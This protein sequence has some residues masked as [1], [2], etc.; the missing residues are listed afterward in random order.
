MEQPIGPEP[1]FVTVSPRRHRAN[2]MIDASAFIA[3]TM[4]ARLVLLTKC[5]KG[6]A[7]PISTPI[8][9]HVRLNE[10]QATKPFFVFEIGEETQREKLFGAGTTDDEGNSVYF[11]PFTA[12]LHVAEEK[13]SIDVWSLKYNTTDDDISAAL[14]RYGVVERVSSSLNGK[15][16]M[17]KATVLFESEAAVESMQQNQV[18]CVNIGSDTG[19]VRRLGTSNITFNPELTLKLTNLPRQYTPYDVALLLN[20][21]GKWHGITMPFQPRLG[22]RLPEAFVFFSNKEQQATLS[23]QKFVLDDVSGLP[24]TTSW[25]SPSTPTCFQCGAT[26]HRRAEGCP[27]RQHFLA[28][29]EKRRMNN[30]RIFSKVNTPHPRVTTQVSHGATPVTTRRKPAA[31]GN[32]WASGTLPHQQPTQSRAPVTITSVSQTT[33]STD[34]A[35][36]WKLALDTMS[37]SVNERFQAMQAANAHNFQSLDNTISTLATM[38]QQLIPGNNVAPAEQVTFTQYAPQHVAIEEDMSMDGNFNTVETEEEEED[39]LDTPLERNVAHKNNGKRIA[40]SAPSTKTLAKERQ[41]HLRSQT[42]SNTQDLLQEVQEL[43]V[44]KQQAQNEIRLQADAIRQLQVQLAGILQS[45][46]STILSPTPQPGQVF[47][48]STQLSPNTQL[49]F[50]SPQTVTQSSVDIPSFN[51]HPSPESS[52]A[53]MTTPEFTNSNTSQY[54][55]NNLS[56]TAPNV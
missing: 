5:M 22:R 36:A 45:Q 49:N 27:Q 7:V 56:P 50:G 39:D 41:Q 32:V 47:V 25:V 44:F 31:A 9:R 33:T 17:R 13:R 14:S 40:V 6:I 16:T 30:Q 24:K 28:I 10:G 11:I 51:T 3:P 29:A 46:S 48:Q 43:R 34:R 55:V 15:H 53:W 54:S 18:S 4:K 12:D 20:N 35:P 8:I 2:V 38:I 42:A 23:N 1:D 21:Y 37:V 19:I 26:D 52:T